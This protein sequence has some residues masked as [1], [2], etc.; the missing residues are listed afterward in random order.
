MLQ[1][2]FFREQKDRVVAGLKKR[3]WADDA[4]EHTVDTVLRLDNTRRSNQQELDATLGEIK[5]LSA[6]I[7]E[8][9][10]SGNHTEGGVLRTKVTSLKE[11]SKAL[12]T[13]SD[14]TL[15][16]LDDILIS[17]PNLPNE[18]VPFGKGADDNEVCFWRK[19]NCRNSQLMRC[20]IGKL[21]KNILFLT[22]N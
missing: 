20:R 4:I 5:Q 8:L 11:K 3:N 7:G 21:L 16:A 10:K 15:K 6:K 12:E 1:L 9:M 14:E 17:L 22:S 18:T 19:M 13:Q 2:A